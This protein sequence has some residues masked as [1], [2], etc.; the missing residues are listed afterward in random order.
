[1]T[2]NQKIAGGIGAVVAVVVVVYALRKDDP[3]KGTTTS[4][5]TETTTTA[6][7][8][9]TAP[10]PQPPM[11]SASSAG[12]VTSGAPISVETLAQEAKYVESA[13]AALHAGDPKKALAEL[14][15]Y[16]L[17][18]GRGA[19][20]QEAALIKIEAL[21]KVGRKTDALALGMSTRDDPSFAPY[22]GRV[23]GVLEDAG[24]IGPA[25]VNG[26]P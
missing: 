2:S 21:S 19:L 8:P 6:P 26:P 9:R 17:V 18:P 12:P 5:T 23:D 7:D 15:R 1:M 10:T 25:P 13:R 11:P 14:E 3:P 16:E 22:R 20:K 4:T 24:L